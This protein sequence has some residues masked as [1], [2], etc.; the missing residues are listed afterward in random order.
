MRD[1]DLS[2]FATAREAVEALGLEAV[3]ELAFQRLLVMDAEALERLPCVFDDYQNPTGFRCAWQC[4]VCTAK[5]LRTFEA[6]KA[7][8]DDELGL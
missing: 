3:E 1:G 8:H 6:L 2:V 4:G 7:Q 5:G